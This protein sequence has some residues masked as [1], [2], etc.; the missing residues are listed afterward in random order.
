MDTRKRK[1]TDDSLSKSKFR[2]TNHTNWNTM[3]SASSIRNYMLDDPLLDW[4]KYY[5]IT[6][7]NG[8]PSNYKTNMLNKNNY[9][10][11][12]YTN[13]NSNNNNYTN[14]IMEQGILFEEKVLEYLMDNFNVVNVGTSNNAQ[15]YDK[16][17]ETI[18][19]MKQGIDIIY[20]GVLH[21]YD[22]KL[23]GVPDLL[24][25]SDK[26]NTIFNKNIKI[27]LAK[28]I[29]NNK[30]CKYYYLVVDIKHSTLNLNSDQTF[31]KNNNSILAYKGQICI[32]N[33]ILNKIQ[34]Y[35]S[36]YG[37]ILSKKIVY[38][39]NKYTFIETDFTKNIGTINLNDNQLKNKVLKG[40]DWIR[41]MRNYGHNW[42]LLPKPSVS[43]LYPNMK[44]DKDGYYRKLKNVLADRI[45]E[46]TNIW[47]CGYEK[48][49]ISH[50]KKIYKWSDHRLNSDI[51]CINNNNIKTMIDSILEVNRNNNK[52][53][54]GNLRNDLT[55]KNTNTNTVEFYIDFETLNNDIGQLG[56][57]IDEKDIIFMVCIGWEQNNEFNHKTFY[58]NEADHES[59]YNMINNMWEFINNKL[60]ELNKTKYIFIHWTNAEINFYN[61]FL[62]KNNNILNPF[63]SFDLY[64]LFINNKIVVKGAFNFSL[65]S[66]AN[67]MFKNNFISTCWDSNSICSNGL[68]A[69]LLAYKYYKT[70]E[71]K[72]VL[73]D[74]IRYNMI[75]C[76][77]MYEIL[78]YLR[79]NY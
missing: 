36:K 52:I 71:N 62:K 13:N 61:K 1:N 12:N 45:H 78:L 47:W 49:C 11:N 67:A 21:D 14:F 44:N 40:I 7:I 53:N 2:R 4:L 76:K 41:R 8:S 50:S 23:Y 33:M 19:Y 55:W 27:P 39:K 68:E 46:I 26:F 22:L 57:D 20:Q 24:V 38:T 37:F 5:S 72:N 79:N 56:V 70:K 35:N 6:D 3:I 74:I 17:I 75:D 60:Q 25:R 31:I 18:N 16:Y 77:V 10:N 34:N 32:Y 58:V 59:E 69:M 15:S 73:N 64:K 29:I 43:E 48:R 51:L 54:I 30:T 66:I 28:S 9:T 65:K 42:K 63:I